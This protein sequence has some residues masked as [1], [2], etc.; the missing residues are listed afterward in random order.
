MFC[1][2]IY[3]CAISLNTFTSDLK[4]LKKD[5]LSLRRV[6]KGHLSSQKEQTIPLNK[7]ICKKDSVV[8]DE[9]LEG[10]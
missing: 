1:A 7:E 4:L 6:F 8:S 2:L 10:F 3:H 9:V 5:G